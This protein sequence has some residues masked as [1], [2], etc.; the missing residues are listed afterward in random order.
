MADL[1]FY[2]DPACP[3]AWRT[4]LWVREVQQ[5]RPLQVQWKLF[6]LTEIHRGDDVPAA[7]QPPTDPV[8]RALVQARRQGGNEAVERLY[9]ALGRARHERRENLKN[10]GVV[11]AALEEAGLPRSLLRQ[12]LDDPSTEQEALAE[13]R[14]SVEE[15]GA[16]GVPWLILGSR[17]F[18]LFGPVISEVPRGDAALA[19]WDHVAWLLEQP[20]FY[21]LKRE[22]A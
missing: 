4:A 20:H 11:E 17:S 13:H 16:F 7:E 10:E 15:F 2:F 21:E 12:A 8:M 22:R 6:S 9:L 5:M 18:G 1:K 19:L 3:W 14:E